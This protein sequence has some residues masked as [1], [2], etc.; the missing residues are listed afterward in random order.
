MEY[1]S[2]IKEE[3]IS[4]AATAEHYIKLNYSNTQLQILHILTHM[5]KHMT[6]KEEK[7]QK[8]HVNLST[9]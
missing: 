4:F 2:A 9:E 8:I 7:P 3:I 5:L 6:N 1:N